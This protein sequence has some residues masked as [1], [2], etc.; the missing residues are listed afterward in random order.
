MFNNHPLEAIMKT[1]SILIG[2]A[3]LVALVSGTAG[4]ADRGYMLA[5]S[6]AA[7]HGPAGRSPGAIPSLNG[8]DKDFIVKA[9]QEFKSDAKPATV[10]NRLAKGY[11]DEEID[12][13]ATWFAAQQ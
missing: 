9:L 5:S 8:K 3:A 12:A 2:A 4:A 11:S 1:K 10:M 6:C 13:I 7:C